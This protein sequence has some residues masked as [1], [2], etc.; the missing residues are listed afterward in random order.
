[1]AACAQ[2]AALR[3][4]GEAL[5]ESAAMHTKAQGAF[6]PVTA[7]PGVAVA[8]GRQYV[9]FLSVSMDQVPDEALSRI[10]SVQLVESGEAEAS[11]PYAEGGFVV[12]G[13]GF[14]PGK[15]TS[16]PWEDYG[17]EADAAFSA[18]FSASPVIASVAPSSVA[19]GT[20]VTIDGSGFT[21]ATSVVFGEVPASFTVEAMTGSAPL[22]PAGPRAR[23]TFMWSARKAPARIRRLTR[24]GLIEQSRSPGT[25]LA[26]GAR[27]SVRLSLGRARVAADANDARRGGRR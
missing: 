14:E 11:P 12:L 8:P 3:V 20:W 23:W 18:T 1:L 27:I 21:G 22:R 6:E 25:I 10:D 4:V 16:T 26:A 5:Y 17:R 15:W 9:L 19:A 7:E 2:K 24:G 13:N